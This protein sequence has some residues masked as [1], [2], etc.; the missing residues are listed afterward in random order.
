MN[1]FNAAD[2][3]RFRLVETTDDVMSTWSTTYPDVNPQT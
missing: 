2:R 1:V 3:D